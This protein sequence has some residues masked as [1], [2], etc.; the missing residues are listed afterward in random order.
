[1]KNA[2]GSRN[3]KLWATNGRLAFVVD[4]HN[5]GSKVGMMAAPETKIRRYSY[6]PGIDAFLRSKVW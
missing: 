1:M 6:N 5:I 4:A 2:K 3:P